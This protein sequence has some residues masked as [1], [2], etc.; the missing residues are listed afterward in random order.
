[1]DPLSPAPTPVPPGSGAAP[2]PAGASADLIKDTTTQTFAADVLEP[3]KDVPVI[4]DFWAPWCGPCRQLTPMLEKAV[5][6]A[7]GAVRLVKMNI[8]DHPEVA[9]Q[10]RVQSIPAVFAFKDGQPVDGFMGAQP[11]SQIKEF[12]G[13]LAGPIGPSRAEEICQAAA[14]AFDAGDL[15]GAAQ[16][17]AQCL[18]EDPGHMPAIAGLAQCY[19][20]NGDLPQAEQTLSLA[21]PDARNSAE[22]TAALAA[23]T[24][25][26]KAAEVGDVGAL[27]AR[28]AQ[29]EKD[30]QARLDL[31]IAMSAAGQ[32][33]AAVT[34]LLKIVEMDRAW[35]DEA[36]RKQL[37]EFFEAYGPTDDVTVAGR[38]QLS[39]L[40]FS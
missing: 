16:L 11:E 31:A 36:A 32:R 10:L 39:S 18:Q 14:A 5:T 22:I 13:R 4:I 9:Q 21:P 17:F 37:V 30:H 7:Q 24:A 6:A 2:N 28:L 3:S 12:I 1:M 38:R 40:L 23:L 26:Q 34:H 19:I 25:A 20:Q 8:D 29:N 35:N 27:E 15:A 33:E